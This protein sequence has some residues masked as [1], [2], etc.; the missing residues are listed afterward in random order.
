MI[1]VFE[2]Y[3]E[4]PDSKLDDSGIVAIVGKRVTFDGHFVSVFLL[5]IIFLSS[6]ITLIDYLIY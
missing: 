1:L 2:R 6:L 3:L 4:R 5:Q